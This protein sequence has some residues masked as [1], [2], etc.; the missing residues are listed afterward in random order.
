M[1]FKYNYKKYHI[2]MDNLWN[3][4]SIDQKQMDFLYFNL[5]M[6]DS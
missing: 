6:I 2:C 1:N 4:A 5:P 3:F